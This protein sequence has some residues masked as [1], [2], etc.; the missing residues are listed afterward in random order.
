LAVDLDTS[1]CARKDN[2]S[3]TPMD[4][5]LACQ[6]A[7]KRVAMLAEILGKSQMGS[8]SFHTLAE[9]GDLELWKLAMGEQSSATIGNAL[10]AKNANGK[11]PLSLALEKGHFNLVENTLEDEAVAVRLDYSGG[12]LSRLISQEGLLA[13]AM[14]H[15]S[16]DVMKEKDNLGRTPLITAAAANEWSA[17]KLM[18]HTERLQ[19]SLELN[20][21]SKDGHTCLTSI[22]AARAKLQLQE[23]SHAVKGDSE[24]MNKCRQEA[25]KLW[26]LVKL[27]LQLEKDIFGPSMVAGRD[28]GSAA[29]R[30]QMT[31]CK[32]IKGPTMDEVEKEFRRLYIFVGK[33]KQSATVDKPAE[34]NGIEKPTLKPVLRQKSVQ[35]GAKKEESKVN[36]RKSLITLDDLRD[37]AAF[38][39]A[40][41][42]MT[43]TI[44]DK[45]KKVKKKSGETMNKELSIDKVD[46]KK[47]PQPEDNN[48]LSRPERTS[49]VDKVLLGKKSPDLTTPS[50]EGKKS[51]QPAS[52]NNNLLT[53]PGRTSRKSSGHKSPS[54]HERTSPKPSSKQD[55]RMADNVKSRK[56]PV[57]PKSAKEAAKV[58]NSSEKCNGVRHKS[59]EVDSLNDRQRSKSG[60]EGKRSPID[61]LRVE[62]ETPISPNQDDEDRDAP[63]AKPRRR[64]FSFKAKRSSSAERRPPIPNE[65]SPPPPENGQNPLNLT[66]GE[67]EQPRRNEEIAPLDAGGFVGIDLDGFKDASTQTEKVV[68]VLD[69]DALSSLPLSV[70]NELSKYLT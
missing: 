9:L 18:L 16:G 10:N 64:V 46:G 36:N 45:K 30:K 52:N 50:V 55:K 68:I 4:A 35:E 3:R 21:N 14:K 59:G 60:N 13:K 17:V 26:E 65:K 63:K 49:I 43:N 47:S 6:D 56:S 34:E 31:S 1:V 48:L 12:V 8:S 57:P 33:R 15:C 61:P 5:V 11:S 7:V 37:P 70:Q 54:P 22:L 51:P 67:L 44:A 20:A 41:Q 58:A 62:L 28:G 69:V 40:V 27:I 38:E 32:V 53:K 25:S 23:Q 42:A 24:A 2:L 66:N 19:T 39:Q 29:L